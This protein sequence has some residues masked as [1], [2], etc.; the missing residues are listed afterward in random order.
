M[1]TKKQKMEL[2]IRTPYRTLVS[3][4]DGFQRVIT[5]TNEAALVI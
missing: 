1:F 4:F 2:T 3:D 5:K